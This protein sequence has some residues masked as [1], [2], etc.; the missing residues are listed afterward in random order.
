MTDFKYAEPFPLGEDKT[1]YRKLTSEHV[2]TG[3]FEGTA[4]LKVAPQALEELSRQA[5]SDVN[6]FFRTRHL[7]ALAHSLKDPEASDNDRYVAFTLL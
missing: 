5:L 2:S 7:E 6:Y 4:V 1:T 3:E